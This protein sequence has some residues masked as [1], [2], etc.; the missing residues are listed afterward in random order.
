MH[1]VKVMTQ[2]LAELTD[3]NI[4]IHNINTPTHKLSGIQKC[5]RLLEYQAILYHCLN[6][7]KIKHSAIDIMLTCSSMYITLEPYFYI[8]NFPKCMTVIIRATSNAYAILQLMEQSHCMM[9]IECPTRS[10][11]TRFIIEHLLAR[12]KNKRPHTRC[13]SCLF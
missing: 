13:M 5:H 11:F 12:H 4:A 2:E 8:R 3:V 6:T 1:N 7:M 9:E 10:V